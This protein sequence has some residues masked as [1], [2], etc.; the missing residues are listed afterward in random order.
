MNAAH[1]SCPV[2]IEFKTGSRIEA[3]EPVSPLSIENQ[4]TSD[5]DAKSP[6]TFVI[7]SDDQRVALPTDQIVMAQDRDGS[8]T[9]GLGGMS[10]EGMEDGNLV[11]WRVQDLLPEEL[12]SPQ[13]EL[14]VMVSSDAIAH[15]HVNG[16][17][18]WPARANG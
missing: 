7:L 3:F 11:F 4:A 2:L 17:N 15:V 18:V 1:D 9:I 6:K 16:Q 12:L 8:A 10:F 14:K 5:F 13:R